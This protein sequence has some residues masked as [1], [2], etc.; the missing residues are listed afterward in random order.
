M[1]NLDKMAINGSKVTVGIFFFAEKIMYNV[2][3]SLTNHYNDTRHAQ[4][5]EI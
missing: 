3:N 1:I 2:S 4:I 5:R